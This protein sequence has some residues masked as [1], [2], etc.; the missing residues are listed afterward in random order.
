MAGNL[1]GADVAELRTL[2]KQFGKTADQLLQQSTQLTSHINSTTSWKGQDAVAFRSEWNGSHRA[3]LQQAAF[4]LQQESKK[5]LENANQQEKASNAGT[6]SGGTG[7]G[8]EAGPGGHGP[9]PGQGS[10]N[11]WGPDWL[12]DPDSPF[13]DGWDIYGLTKAFP[14]LRAGLFDLGAMLHKSR[15]GDF[16]DPAAWRAFQNSNEFSKFFNLSNNLFEGKFHEV[17]NL[18]E[19][20]NAFKYID[21][22]SKGLGVLGVGLDTLDAF[23]NFQE[24]DYGSAAY[25]TTKALLGAGS[26]LPP[27][28]GTACMVASGALALYDNVPV[29]HDSVNYVG[30]KI[31]D[32]AEAVGGAISDGVDA[33]GDF[34]GF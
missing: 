30:D 13:R 2:A 27:P 25:S 28:A 32:G 11:P 3:M 10:N 26:F 34:F 20:S 21:G 18:A 1:W 23:N 17:L 12:A 19:G 31:A 5:L 24:G 15:I 4:A 16:L 22:F 7:P 8:V 6:G 29:I 33:V 14:N 9:V